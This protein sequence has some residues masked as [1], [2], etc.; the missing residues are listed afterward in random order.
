MKKKKFP[1]IQ[2]SVLTSALLAY[3]LLYSLPK[4]QAVTGVNPLRA[5]I[6]SKPKLIAHGGGN[7]EFPDNTLEAFYHAYSINP[8][9]M[10]ETDVNLTKD[11]V[12]ILSHD[13]TLDRKTNLIEANIIDTNYQDLVDQEIDFSFHNDVEPN[14]NGYN[15]SG[16]FKRYTN[17]LGHEV[18][19][20]DVL[21]PLD[22]QPRH[23]QK[24]LVSTLEEL[25]TLFPTSLI[26][27]EIKQ[28]GAVGLQS[29]QAVITLMDTYKN[30][31]QTFQRI[32]LA[33]F[34]ETVFNAM[35]ELKN[36]SHPELQ[37]SP[38]TMGV[39]QFFILHTL[40]LSYFFDLPVHVL[41]L[42]IERFGFDLSTRA[43]IEN[44]HAHNIAVHYWTIDD[45]DVMEELIA[46]GAD[47]IMTNRPSLLQTVIDRM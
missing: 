43:L 13:T 3:A 22:V 11:G 38:E 42:P 23:P 44:A 45:E 20:L 19:P 6:G 14:S 9:V 5:E 26:N 41:Q 4:P 16:T 1:V 15:V 12:V 21:Y 46:M 32:V 2:L 33:T 17:Y 7:H 8:D 34:H 18:T 25:I 35:K 24:F 31:H 27:V 28:N 40:G 36:T 10:L 47:G 39:L 29:L 30:T 37:F